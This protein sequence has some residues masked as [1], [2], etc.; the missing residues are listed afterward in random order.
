MLST[1][2]F[3]FFSETYLDN[4]SERALKFPSNGDM[5]QI[6]EVGQVPEIPLSKN[7]RKKT[8]VKTAD[9]WVNFNFSFTEI[10]RCYN[11]SFQQVSTLPMITN[12]QGSYSW[13]SVF[14]FLRF[15]TVF[16]R[17]YKIYVNLWREKKERKKGDVC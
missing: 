17:Y 6:E 5:I 1:T 11:C 4:L 7:G 8:R 3:F 15:I 9:F 12:R 14:E 13:I 16:E 2:V 10:C